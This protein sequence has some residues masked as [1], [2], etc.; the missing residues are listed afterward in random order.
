M[1]KCKATPTSTGYT[2]AFS[3]DQG[4]QVSVT[5]NVQYLHSLTHLLFDAFKKTDWNLDVAAI[6]SAEPAERPE[7]LM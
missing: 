7:R 3:P 5:L 1:T 4:Q 6:G 2:L